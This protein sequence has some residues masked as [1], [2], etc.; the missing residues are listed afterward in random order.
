MPVYHHIFDSKQA[1]APFDHRVKMCKIALQDNPE[2]NRDGKVQVIRIEK[3][4][5]TLLGTKGGRVG[6]ID[7]VEHLLEQFE[8]YSFT[9]LLGGDTF[10]DLCGGKWRRGS[11]LAQLVDFVVVPREG[12]LFDF[13]PPQ[14]CASLRHCSSYIT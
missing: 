3:E 7:V 9:L 4:V 8:G 10:L 6:T 2:V 13:P 12:V 14:V 1:L 5:Y 11:D